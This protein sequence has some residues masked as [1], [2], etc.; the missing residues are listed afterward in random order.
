[1]N[2]LQYYTSLGINLNQ[3]LGTKNFLGKLQT[4]PS[5]LQVVPGLESTTDILSRLIKTRDQIAESKEKATNA[6]VSIEN[7]I[8]KT[9]SILNTTNQALSVAQSAVNVQYGVASFSLATA[10]G[11]VPSPN[12]GAV[13]AALTNLNLATTVN[14]Y[15]EVYKGIITKA[16][17]FLEKTLKPN[18]EKAKAQLE[19]INGYI[20]QVDEKLDLFMDVILSRLQACV[21]FI[22]RKSL[23]SIEAFI[24]QKIQEKLAAQ[25]TNQF[26][27]LKDLTKKIEGSTKLIMQLAGAAMPSFD[28]LEEAMQAV[29][30]NTAT[31]D[32]TETN[33]ITN[34]TTAIE[35]A[36]AVIDQQLG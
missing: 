26:T 4:A 17:D 29:D 8:E 9:T 34:L 21:I 36:Q 11:S 22:G 19:T 16:T 1:M 20:V 33:L 2:G 3:S 23:T 25:T 6:I 12:P 14:T 28:G 35:Q 32:E 7:N 30:N 24:P 27:E 13:S 18:L 5:V 31:I 10:A 15:I